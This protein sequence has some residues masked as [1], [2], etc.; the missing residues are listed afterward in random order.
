LSDEVYYVLKRL[1]A[2]GFIDM[3]D[4][5]QARFEQFLQ[6]I[7]REESLIHFR[8]TWAMQWN[9]AAFA[10]LI[11]LS[12]LEDASKPLLITAAVIVIGLALVANVLSFIAVDAAH[13]QISYLIDRIESK[14]G[15]Q[16]DELWER[17]E[18]IRPFGEKTKV[19]ARARAVSKFFPLAFALIWL[20]VGYQVLRTVEL[21]F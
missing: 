9:A 6:C 13:D 1:L 20:L 14:L 4:L 21:P 8:T 19:H 17:S 15:C 7:D 11:G 5:D 3:K 10:A 18:F 2:D 12:Q 16:S